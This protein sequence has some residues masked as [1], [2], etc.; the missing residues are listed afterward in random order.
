MVIA[1][2]VYLTPNSAMGAVDSVNTPVIAF[3][4]GLGGMLVWQISLVME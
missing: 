3:E 1:V 4:N 2:P